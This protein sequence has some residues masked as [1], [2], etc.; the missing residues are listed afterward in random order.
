MKVAH[1]K[2]ELVDRVITQIQMDIENMD[3]TSIEELLW[4]LDDK[5]LIAYL[6]EE[7]TNA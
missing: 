5:F 4:K 1:D 6:P 2:Q 7:T 3:T